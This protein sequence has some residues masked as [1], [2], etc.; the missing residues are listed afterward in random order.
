MLK[1]VY[2]AC[3]NSMRA[4][5][6][7]VVM[8]GYLGCEVPYTYISVLLAPKSVHERVARMAFFIYNF[9][10]LALHFILKL[11]VREHLWHNAHCAGAILQKI[12]FWKPH[13][14]KKMRTKES[15]RKTGIH[16]KMSRW[17]LRRLKLMLFY[18]N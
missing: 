16:S 18:G 10:G 5:L 3:Y 15:Q 1:R 4:H 17:I 14:A 12:N 7:Q 11:Q 2:S 6:L 8:R 9:T 13:N